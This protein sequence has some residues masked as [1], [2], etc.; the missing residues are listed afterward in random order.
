MHAEDGGVPISMGIFTSNCMSFQS[1]IRE[2]SEAFPLAL[3]SAQRINELENT[4]QKFCHPSIEYTQK[5]RVPLATFNRNVH[6]LFPD[7][8]HCNR[9][10]NSGSSYAYLSA[11]LAD[12]PV[13][14]FD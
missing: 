3:Q 1:C 8:K 2:L 9:Y 4:H 5:P 14:D 11:V 7:R 6:V 13:P 12:H 10:R